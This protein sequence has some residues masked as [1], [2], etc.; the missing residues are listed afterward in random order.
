MGLSGAA[1]PRGWCWRPLPSPIIT[2]E[3]VQSAQCRSCANASLETTRGKDQ[4]PLRRMLECSTRTPQ[5]RTLKCGNLGGKNNQFEYFRIS[6]NY[7]IQKYLLTANL[8]LGTL[9]LERRALH[10][11]RYLEKA[12]LFLGSYLFSISLQGTQTSFLGFRCLAKAFSCEK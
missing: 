6:I 1:L 9:A 10:V 12:R 11:R 3:R 2:T 7:T 4:K 5:L 8:A